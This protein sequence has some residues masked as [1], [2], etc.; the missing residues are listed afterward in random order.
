MSDPLLDSRIA[1]DPMLDPRAEDLLAFD[2]DQVAGAVRELTAAAGEAE[3][4][5]RG[6]E[7]ARHDGVWTGHAAAT[8]RSSIGRVPAELRKL[9][10]GFSA[11][12]NAMYRYSEATAVIQ[13]DFQ[14]VMRQAALAG[15][16]LGSPDDEHLRAELARQHRR[17]HELLDEFEAH[18]S[19]AR[20]AIAAAAHMAPRRVIG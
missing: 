4:T 6:L 1:A 10:H 12:A 5:Q 15:E 20:A 14:R 13:H 7:A 18:R 19:A 8:F 16:G 2:P 3:A 17:A 9:W 11:V